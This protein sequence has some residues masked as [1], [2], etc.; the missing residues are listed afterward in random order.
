[1]SQF[2]DFGVQSWCFRQTGSNEALAGKVRALGLNKV[3]LCGVHADFSKPDAFGA[4]VD[5]YS[6][7]GVSI[8]SLG[9]QTFTGDAGEK[10]WFE[11]AVAAGARHIS[12]HFQID[13]YVRAVPRVRQWSREFGVR[14][15]IHCHGGYQFGGSPDVI[16]HLL[17]L[18]GPE[19]GLCIDTAWAMQIG[20][21]R[22]NPTEWAKRYAGRIYGVHFKDFIFQRN[23]QWE[24]VVVG[25]GTL[26]LPGFAAALREGGFDGMSVIEY[27]ADPE[28]PD[29]AL[30]QCVESMRAALAGV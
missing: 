17:A 10:A 7:G 21:S 3:E 22:G 19:I 1:M 15:G 16:E 9:V 2:I 27:E 24:D 23:G 26:D 13:S 29:P 8:V 6:A 14:V 28:N 4:V 12:C 20:P 5:T 30:K 18:G 11:C 25:T